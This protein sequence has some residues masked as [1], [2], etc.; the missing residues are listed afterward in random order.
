MEFRRLIENYF[1]STYLLEQKDI[2]DSVKILNELLDDTITNKTHGF[3]V[4]LNKLFK[5]LILSKLSNLTEDGVHPN[6]ICFIR[7]LILLP[8]NQKKLNLE[9]K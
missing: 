2:T 4:S 9:R 8:F 5:P 3:E 7:F 1:I 6:E